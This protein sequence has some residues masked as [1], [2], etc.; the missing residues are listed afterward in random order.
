MQEEISKHS[1]KIYKTVKDP[2]H[3]F[4]EKAKEITIEIFIIVFA[5]SLSIWLH[6]WSEHR[7]EQKE[8]N[9]FLKELNEDLAA[10]I[11][12][13]EENKNTATMLNNDYKFMLALK[14]NKTSDSLIGSHTNFSLL[15]T[16]FNVGRY[17]G[18]K[19]S[20]KIG[21][22]EDDKIKNKILSYYQQT[23]PNLTSRVNFIN[24]EQLRILDVDA[25]NLSLN[26]VYTTQ[27]MQSK[28]FNLQYNTNSLIAT[29]EE[30]IKQLNEIILENKKKE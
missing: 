30:V 2:K 21:T 11:K 16:N 29:Y 3:T 22:I 25:G 17:E 14:K 10:D 24:A 6:G 8:A 18:F 12:V 9:K 4:S 20:G 5:V 28:Y 15:S 13:L 7:H 23:I 19:S 26:D 1:R 27:R